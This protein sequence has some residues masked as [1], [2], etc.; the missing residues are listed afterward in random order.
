[1]DAIGSTLLVHAERPRFVKVT[2]QVVL[3][4]SCTAVR[5]YDRDAQIA[6]VRGGVVGV[7]R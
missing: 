3:A 2:V 5:C 6:W 1:V 7:F 4:R